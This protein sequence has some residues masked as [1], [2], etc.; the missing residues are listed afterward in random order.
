MFKNYIRIALRNLIRNKIFTVINILGLSIGLT[1]SILILIFV[2]HELGFDKFHEK[3][4][5]IYRLA[6][7]EKN[8]NME[9]EHCITS[10]P[11]G[12]DL[13]E[14]IPEIQSYT[15]YKD[16][17][18][19]M[20]EY[21]NNPQIRSHL[22]W[23]DS[24]FFE[25]FSFKLISGD[26]NRV[27]KDPQSLVL[28]RS[29][30]NKLFPKTQDV[31]GKEILV[32][33]NTS[34]TI[35]GIMEDVPINSHLQFEAIGS[36][37]T[38]VNSGS[39]YNKWDGNFGYNAYFLCEENLNMKVLED[40]MDQ[41]YYDKMLHRF[42]DI[43]QIDP[44]LQ[45]LERI[46][47]HSNLRWE[48]G[49]SGSI[50]TVYIFSIIAF[51]VLMIA[52]INFTNLNTAQSIRRTKEIGI[53]KVNGATKKGIIKQFLGESV[54]LSLLAL[55]LALILVEVLLPI[56]N[57]LMEKDLS[58]Y[59]A[60][61][62]SL[63]FIIP[64]LVLLLGIVSGIYPA[65]IASSYKPS[66]GIK[67]ARI[68]SKAGNRIR[69]ILVVFQYVISIVL[70]LS[71]LIIK[72]QMNYINNKNLG[73]QK[74]RIISVSL[75]NNLAKEKRFLIRDAFR[76][77]PEVKDATVASSYLGRGL[78]M[79][80]Y[81]PEGVEKPM[82]IHALYVDPYYLNTMGLTL[83]SGRN[84]YEKSEGDINHILI[85]ETL[86][87]ELNWESPLGKIINRNNV[88]YKVIGVVNDF[89]FA[90]LQREIEPVIFT[91]RERP[92][93]LLVQI[94]PGNIGESIKKLKTNWGDMVKDVKFDYRFTD[95]VFDN[96]YSTETRFGHIILFFNIL[97]ILIASM[98]LFGLT[99]LST[100][101]RTKEIGI[102]KAL[103]ATTAGITRMLIKDYTK[104]LLMANIIAW[105]IAYYF[106]KD[107]LQSFA[108]RIDIG[109]HYFLMALL[110]VM[111]IAIITVSWHA[112]RT[113]NTDPAKTLRYE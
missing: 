21:K 91:L 89:H 39:F 79:N 59:T 5:N 43:W 64:L 41:I 94:K 84:F 75:F 63:F 101:Q 95:E 1:I 80:G 66:E 58:F 15:R 81:L 54:L 52:G 2:N 76:Q 82:M 32:D 73:F 35:T 111:V 27:L 105:P 96:L 57:Q 85:N 88:D 45:P 53:R 36:F 87:E 16:A 22:A 12:P 68:K 24:S 62:T 112:I 9:Y 55:I 97:A 113:A 104:W 70:I 4:A 14:A 69:N 19:R 6:A 8:P 38:L 7:W 100:A 77:L 90:P 102:R 23:A 49:K 34:Y 40:K 46:Y 56:F 110:I 99:S 86:A 29:L 31:I 51:L 74:E 20:M 44:Y 71:M 26:P 61:N 98:G 50:R 92:S 11:M 42:E 37:S 17:G 72:S 67:G 65:F 33:Q 48:P 28:S 106:M 47:L 93:F 30:V 13:C 78:T 10:P 109:I 108:Y 25:I 107:W 3:K 103:G 60:H 18:M 83:K